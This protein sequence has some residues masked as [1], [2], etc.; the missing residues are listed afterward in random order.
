MSTATETLTAARDA[1]YAIST[2]AVT[3]WRNRNDIG[4]AAWWTEKRRIDALCRASKEA[5]QAVYDARIEHAPYW[6]VR[7]GCYSSAA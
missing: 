4:T 7:P 3:A 5:Q 6:W 1:A 2:P